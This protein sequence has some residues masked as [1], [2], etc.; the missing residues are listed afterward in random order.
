LSIFSEIP[1]EIFVEASNVTLVFHC[2]KHRSK[3]NRKPLY[4]AD[5]DENIRFIGT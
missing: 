5:I 4:E 2:S 1:P 3:Q